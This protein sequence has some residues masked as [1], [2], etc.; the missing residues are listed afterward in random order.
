MFTPLFYEYLKTFNVN[1]FALQGCKL[2]I[3]IL[4]RDYTSSIFCEN[5]QQSI[6]MPNGLNTLAKG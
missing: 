4:K 2:H 3:D 5:P 1:Y 6:Y